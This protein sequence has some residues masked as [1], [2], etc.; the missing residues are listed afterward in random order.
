VAP[1]LFV[2][3]PDKR[4][5]AVY[6]LG[7]RGALVATRTAV[8]SFSHAVA[9]GRRDV[10]ARRLA[11]R[12]EPELRAASAPSR[13]DALEQGLFFIDRRASSAIESWWGRSSRCPARRPSRK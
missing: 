6:S 13:H 4:L 7:D 11:R 10:G 5:Y 2:C 1:V 8:V 12:R 9:K 3:D